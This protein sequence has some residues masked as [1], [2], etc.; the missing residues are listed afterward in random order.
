MKLLFFVITLMTATALAGETIDQRDTADQ[1]NNKT[2]RL[3][4]IIE[5]THVVVITEAEFVPFSQYL[6]LSE[7]NTLPPSSAG[8]HQQ[9]GKP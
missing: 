8:N 9:A 3:K 6:G 1:P 4:H 5:D 7:M 2:S